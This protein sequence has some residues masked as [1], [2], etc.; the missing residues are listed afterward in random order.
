[1]CVDISN[2]VGVKCT[3]SPSVFVGRTTLSHNF[4]FDGHY[5]SQCQSV[6]HTVGQLTFLHISC[7]VCVF[8]N[9]LVNMIVA[10][11]AW[12]CDFS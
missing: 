1:V 9:V 11:F 10:T 3:I 8:V 2:A 7:A 6:T 12:I 5:E 4:V